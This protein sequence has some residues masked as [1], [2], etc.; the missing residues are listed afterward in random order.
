MDSGIQV[1]LNVVS[2]TEPTAVSKSVTQHRGENILYAHGIAIKLEGCKCRVPLSHTAT[3]LVAAWASL[4]LDVRYRHNMTFPYAV[5]R[6][7]DDK[8]PRHA[9]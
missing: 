9:N 6:S 4:A 8:D 3:F 7:R 1:G 2:S 5:I